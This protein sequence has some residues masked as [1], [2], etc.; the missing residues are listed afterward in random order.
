M[1]PVESLKNATDMLSPATLYRRLYA[2]GEGE[3][4][5]RD[6][7]DELEVTRIPKGETPVVGRIA[8]NHA[9]PGDL[10]RAIRSV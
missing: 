3:I 10:I 5:I 1:T 2:Y 4:F 9:T 6:L 7:G 8:R